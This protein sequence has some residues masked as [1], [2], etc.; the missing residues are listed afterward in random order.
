MPVPELPASIRTGWEMTKKV[1]LPSF[2]PCGS[3]QQICSITTTAV[4]STKLK[5]KQIAIILQH[6]V[7]SHIQKKPKPKPPTKQ[8]SFL[9][10]KLF[11]PPSLYLEDT[12][13]LA[14]ADNCKNFKLNSCDWD[15]AAA[16]DGPAFDTWIGFGSN[17]LFFNFFLVGRPFALEVHQQWDSLGFPSAKKTFWTKSLVIYCINLNC[18][19]EDSKQQDVPHSEQL[20]AS[21]SY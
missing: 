8:S 16:P 13:V 2:S 11:P 19:K 18:V 12:R 20:V 9:F 1:N 7:I 15:A 6:C 17:Y 4:I 3:P 10:P 21:Y 5:G 14:A